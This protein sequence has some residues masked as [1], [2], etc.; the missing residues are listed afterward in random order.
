[1]KTQSLLKISKR[2]RPPKDKKTSNVDEV[3]TKNN[4]DDVVKNKVN[5]LLTD[6]TQSIKENLK[7]GE[8]T[9]TKIKERKWL[10]EQVT[11]LS[12]ENEK[13]RQHV[14]YLTNEYQPTEEN[15][16]NENKRA[17]DEG[18]MKNVI[19]FFNDFQTNYIPGVDPNG[20]PNMIIWPLPFVNR[21]IGYFPF[22]GQHRRI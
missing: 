7:E 6:V 1:M 4:I 3:I 16:N 11:L 19:D 12:E 20:R 2:G 17:N 18:I 14:A 5:E 15:I 21:M 8:T 22:L 9:E 10:E 13:L